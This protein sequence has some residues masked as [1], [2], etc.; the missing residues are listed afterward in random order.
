MEVDTGMYIR[1]GGPREDETNREDRESGEVETVLDNQTGSLRE[2]GTDRHIKAT[3]SREL[4]TSSEI[5]AGDTRREKNF[6]ETTGK[7]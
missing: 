6:F 7:L 3:G 2:Y 4:I 5:E 1:A